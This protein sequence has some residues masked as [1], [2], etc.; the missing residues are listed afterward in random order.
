MGR[1]FKGIA[2]FCLSVTFLVSVA[3]AG[4]SCKDDKNADVDWFFLYKLPRGAQNKAKVSVPRGDEYVYVD[5]NTPSSAAFWTL[6]PKNIFESD[7]AVAN[8]IAPLTL[9]K[10]PTNLTYAVYNDQPPYRPGDNKTSNGHTKGLFIFDEK[11]GVWLIHSVPKFPE[12]LHRGVYVFPQSGRQFGQ[13][14]LCV[15]FPSSQLETIATHLRLQY[16]NIYDGYAPASL[17]KTHPSLNL[18]LARKFIRE[19]PWVL[20]ATLKDVAQNAYVSFAKHGRYN[21][22]VYSGVVAESLKSNLLASTWRNGAGGKAPADCNDTYT[23]TNIEKLTFNLG[24]QQQMTFKNTED[25][26]KWAISSETAK[27]FVCAGTLNRMHSQY[28]RGGETL[29]FKNA[30]LHKL[31]LKTVTDSEDCPIKA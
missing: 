1:I 19:A 26:S 2:V 17:R 14:M 28:R 25:H 16:P 27:S 10:K 20:T 31:L 6:S 18:L 12:N 24:K 5:S 22:D 4:T 7:G 9:A 11:T 3:D 13:I 8:T 23:V 29:C 30:L 15:T 21:K